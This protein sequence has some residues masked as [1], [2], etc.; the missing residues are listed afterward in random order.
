MQ[1]LLS[2]VALFLLVLSLAHQGQCVGWYRQAF[3][4]PQL[5]TRYPHTDAA[6]MG[7][8]D[9]SFGYHAL[10]GQAN[11]GVE[12]NWFFWPHIQ[13]TPQEE[14]WRKS[15]T[16]VTKANIYRREPGRD[17]TSSKLYAL[18][19]NDSHELY[20]SPQCMSKRWLPWSTIAT[21]TGRALFLGNSFLVFKSGGC[22]IIRKEQNDLLECD[23]Y[24]RR[25]RSV[26]LRLGIAAGV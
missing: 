8:Y 26:L 6:D 13:N 3:T 17:R 11:G 24:Q 12:R 9:G 2:R 15:M 23:D 22:R 5:Q 10:Y 18:L 16:R 21:S 4:K 14:S 19:R 1:H 20:S 7:R 25:N